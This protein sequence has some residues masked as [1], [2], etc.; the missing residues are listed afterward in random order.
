MRLLPLLLVLAACEGPAGP[1]GPP[2]DPGAPGAT[3]DAGAPGTPGAP[4]EAG[5]GPWL[6]QPGVAVKVTDLAFANGSATVSFSLA[7]EHGAPL[8]ASGRLTDGTVAVG[9][10]LAQ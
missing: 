1:A 9:F 10:V 3:G 2:G 8:D 4:G 7:D 5:T 6:T